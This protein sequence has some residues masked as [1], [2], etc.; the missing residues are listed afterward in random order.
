MRLNLCVI[1]LAGLL[2][3]AARSAMAEEK[4]SMVQTALS[5]TT[6]S[7]YVDVNAIWRSGTES[8]IQ[9][10][11]ASEETSGC[12]HWLARFNAWLRKMGFRIWS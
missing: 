7:G 11:A 6:L 1:L 2:L 4:M 3:T 8:A 10:V 5:S 9:V 12:Q